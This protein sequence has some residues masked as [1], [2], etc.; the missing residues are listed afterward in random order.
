MDKNYGF[1]SPESQEQ[2]MTH[3]QR[4]SQYSAN[5][6][7]QVSTWNLIRMLYMYVTI[8]IKEEEVTIWEWVGW[9][10]RCYRG[11]RGK[12]NVLLIYKVIKT[13]IQ[14]KNC[15]F[16]KPPCHIQ[17]FVFFFPLRLKS[18]RQKPAERFNRTFSPCIVFTVLLIKRNVSVTFKGLVTGSLSM[19]QKIY[20]QQK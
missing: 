8:I 3:P 15:L 9:H 5:S 20:G 4:T 16:S 12:S 13:E 7:S 14:R 1:V 11:G 2:E 6:G 19:L 17:S 10:R 18:V